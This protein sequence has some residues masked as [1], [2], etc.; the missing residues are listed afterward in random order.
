MHSVW[1]REVGKS[2]SSIA[3][4]SHLSLIKCVIRLAEKFRKSK[5]LSNFVPDSAV[6]CN[7]GAWR[8]TFSII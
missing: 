2:H 7:G 8:E 1:L 3:D 4:E 6:A 5:V